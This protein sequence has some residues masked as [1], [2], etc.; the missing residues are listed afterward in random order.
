MKGFINL[1]KP[2]GMSSAQAVARVKRALELPKNVKVGHT[3]TLD[4]MASGILPIAVGRA[5]RLF[6]FMLEKYKTYVAEFTFGFETDTLDS[7]GEIVKTAEKI[8]SVEE[9]MAVLP[10][11]LGKIEQLPPQYSAKSVNGIRAYDLARKGQA[12]ELKSCVVEI[13]E[14]EFL[15]AKE[16]N[17]FA[18]RITCGSGTYIRSLCR[19]LAV[20]LGSVATMTA[21]E[22]TKVG[23]FGLENAVKIEDVTPSALLPCE[24]VL[25]RLEKLNISAQQQEMLLQGKR[26]ELSKQNGLYKVF[27]GELVGL[28]QVENN[29]L[30]MKTWLI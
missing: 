12:V 30:K 2:V 6:D 27:N 25:E 20:K 9:I 23:V 29:C 26:V 16:E 5:T 15:E 11:F 22:R 7:E 13:V 1:Y 19:D 14:F 17:K 18:F 3:G 8:P 28:G 24:I 21:L 10:E 4:P